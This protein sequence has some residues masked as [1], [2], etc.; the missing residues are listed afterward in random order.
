M[1]TFSLHFSYN[2]VEGLCKGVAWCTLS[3]V[4]LLFFWVP[5]TSSEDTPYRGNDVKVLQSLL[6]L[7]PYHIIP[8]APPVDGV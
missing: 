1:Y 8:E 7:L 5:V 3:A 6:N 2:C 4:S